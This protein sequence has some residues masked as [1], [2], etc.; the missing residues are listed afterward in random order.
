MWSLNRLSKAVKIVPVIAKADAL[1]LE[2]RDFFRQTIREG[3]RAN[4]IDVYPQKEFDEDADDRMIND[5]IR[6]PHAEHQGHHQ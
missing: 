2:E 4:G 3:L 5:K 1:T 6:D